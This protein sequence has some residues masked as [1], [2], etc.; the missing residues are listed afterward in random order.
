[1]RGFIWTASASVVQI[2]VIT[3]VYKRLPTG[4]MGTYEWGLMLI[5]LLALLS[6]L[7]LSTALVQLREATAEH[8]DA[9][10]WT[11][12]ACGLAVTTAV[13]ALARLLAPVLGGEQPELFVQVTRILCLLIPFASV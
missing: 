5:M 13:F 1:M 3:L 4:E 6:D 9:A 7:G 10:F 12:L 8:F 11:N 2:L